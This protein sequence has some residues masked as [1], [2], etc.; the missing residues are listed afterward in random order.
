MFAIEFAVEIFLSMRT[1]RSRSKELFIC[2]MFGDA[3]K[4]LALGYWLMTA[5]MIQHLPTFQSS[6]STTYKVFATSPSKIDDLRIGFR[7]KILLRHW[8]AF[9]FG[10]VS[11]QKSEN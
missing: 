1:T 3:E 2:A 7:K 6:V 8:T 10:F 5:E 4:I 9:S 11:G